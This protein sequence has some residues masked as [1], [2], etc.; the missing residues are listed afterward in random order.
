MIGARGRYEES[1]ACCPMLVM[2]GRRCYVQR[3]VDHD[4]SGTF[5]DFA[6]VESMRTVF[7]IVFL[8]LQLGLPIRY[9]AGDDSYDERFAWRMFS[10]IRLMKCRVSFTQESNNRRSTVVLKRKAHV[11]WINLM[12]R[13]RMSVVE[14]F[15]RHHC[16]E[17][18]TVDED[19]ALYCD[20]RCHKPSG[21]TVE[22][23]DN[24]EDLCSRFD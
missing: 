11:L 2:A 24:T 5:A 18:R 17:L 8:A 9:Y 10:P 12:S 20:L 23:L 22:M 6:V 4:Q 1:F 7:I 21:D 15:A 14:G 3:R 19:A 13:A 16:A